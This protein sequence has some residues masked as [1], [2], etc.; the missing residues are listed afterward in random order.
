MK[1]IIEGST[2]ATYSA[3]CELCKRIAFKCKIKSMSNAM[4][5]HRERFHPHHRGTIKYKTEKIA[6]P[7]KVSK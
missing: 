1:V 4:R 6:E 3:R 2:G 7:G 5:R